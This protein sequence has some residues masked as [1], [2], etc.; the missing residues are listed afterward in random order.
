MNEPIMQL[1]IAVAGL[2]TALLVN[3]I[4]KKTSE[5][6][7]RTKNETADKYINLLSSTI[8]ECVVAT[9]QTY[10]DSLK[11]QGKFGADA[12][13]TAFKMTLNKVYELLSEDAEKCLL[14]VY[15][16]L[17]LYITTKIEAEVKGNK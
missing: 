3:L 14:E 4:N 16:D 5:I 13:H 11:A 8:Q 2:V 1:V 6:K 15:G 9:N 17:N 12:Q 7:A 10:V